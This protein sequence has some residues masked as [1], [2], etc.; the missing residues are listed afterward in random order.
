MYFKSDLSDDWMECV[1]EFRASSI[2]NTQ[3][4]ISSKVGRHRD[5]ENG[6]HKYFQNIFLIFG[7]R[8]VCEYDFYLLFSISVPKELAK[9]SS[10]EDIAAQ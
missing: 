3:H 6:I 9:K 2:G 1:G 5:C 4:H 7:K 8:T 10:V